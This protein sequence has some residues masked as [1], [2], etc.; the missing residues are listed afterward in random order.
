LTEDNVI[1]NRKLDLPK[2]KK[3]SKTTKKYSEVLCTLNNISAWYRYKKTEIKNTYKQLLKEYFIPQPKQ[4]YKS[5]TI[6]YRI[7]RHNKK[8]IDK[9]N[10]VFA[11]KWIADTLEELG[12]VDNDNVVNFES[13]DTIYDTSLPETMLEIRIIDS[14][15]IW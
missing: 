13:F 1:L 3:R 6:Q 14:E 15:R 4:K 12:Y 7:I 2:F 5:L 10:V 8:N 11:L 9:D